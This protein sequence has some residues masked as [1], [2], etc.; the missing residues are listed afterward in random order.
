[1][2]ITSSD[3][4]TDFCHFFTFPTALGIPEEFCDLAGKMRLPLKSVADNRDM[5]NWA[6]ARWLFFFKMNKSEASKLTCNVGFYLLNL[7]IFLKFPGFYTF[8]ML[9]I[10]LLY[11][12]L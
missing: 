6:E 10:K 1:M 12:L 5:V 8:L 11:I 7:L 3:T 4:T 9:L 2:S